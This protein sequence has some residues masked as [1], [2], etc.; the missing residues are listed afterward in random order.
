MQ[1]HKEVT[2]TVSLHE[3]DVINSRTQGF[4]AL[5][6]GETG[7]IKAELRDQVNAKVTDWREEGKATIVP[8]VLLLDETHL[9]D[10][11]C[12]SFLNRALE[13]DFAPLV[14]MASNR[15]YSR[16]RGTKYSAPHGIPVDLL[17][18]LL[19]ITTSA[20]E[21]DEIREILK[22]RSQEEDVSIE[23]A[24]LEVLVKLGKDTSLRYAL[25]L[26]TVAH[27]CSRRRKAS[28]VAVDDVRRAYDYFLDTERSMA[29]TSEGLIFSE[30]Y[31]HPVRGVFCIDLRGHRKN[32]AQDHFI[33]ATQF[34]SRVQRNDA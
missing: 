12:F 7:E 21:S 6:S 27:M 4:L 24:A 13:S 31:V 19:I 22:L 30:E 14:V 33:S 9:L 2:H 26:I 34:S 5:F 18:R 8:G 25:Q 16:I 23:D 32:N 10:I 20:Y 11:E 1:K 17:D 3:I 15:G 28:Q 29:T